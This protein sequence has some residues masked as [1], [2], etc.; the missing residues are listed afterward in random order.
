MRHVAGALAGALAA[1]LALVA[2]TTAPARP[3]SAAPITIAQLGIELPTLGGAQWFTIVKRRYYS[4]AVMR[5]IRDD[6]H[7]T[8]VRTGW[9]PSRFNTERI[10]WYRED[11]GMD[12]I[13]SAGLKTM[14][15]VPSLHDD[16]L[17]VDDLV[18]NVREFFERYERREFGC[19]QYAEI[20]NEADLPHNGFSDVTQYADYYRRV[21]PIVAAFGVTVV[22]SGTSGKDLPWT[23]ALARLLRTPPAVVPDGYGY[24]PYG[25]PPALMADSVREVARAA[26]GADGSVPNV[27]VTEIGERDPNDLYAAIVQLAHVTPAITIYEYLAQPGEDPEFGLKNDPRRYDAVRRAWAT[28]HDGK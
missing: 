13:C 10:R 7:A 26:M 8:Y 11:Q 27:Y 12:A 23:W 18:A 15:I 22:T 24:H 1:A 16:K 28:L 2:G 20:V 9:V 14:I 19:I 4:A 5:D 21:A 25:V 17:G 3:Q 6:L